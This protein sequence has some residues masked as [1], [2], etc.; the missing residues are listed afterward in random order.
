MQILTV[1]SVE[2]V[3]NDRKLEI[4]YAFGMEHHSDYIF[5]DEESSVYSVTVNLEST[6]QVID[7]IIKN[8]ERFPD[9]TFVVDDLNIETNEIKKLKIS[10]G[11][12]VAF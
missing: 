1:R 12:F 9:V 8:S 10:N 2:K 7:Q 11:E 6:S 3:S 4:H 5:K